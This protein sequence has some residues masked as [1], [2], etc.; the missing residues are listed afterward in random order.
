MACYDHARRATKVPRCLVN[1]ELDAA[2]ATVTVHGGR[3]N[4]E[5]MQVVDGT[6]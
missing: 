2:L 3:M 5:Q 1:G 6:M 4:A